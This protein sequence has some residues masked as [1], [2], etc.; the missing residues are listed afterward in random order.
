[1][2]YKKKSKQ[3]LPLLKKSPL[4]IWER[5]TFVPHFFHSTII[6]DIVVSL[7]QTGLVELGPKRNLVLAYCITT[8]YTVVSFVLPVPSKHPYSK[9]MD[10][11]A[12]I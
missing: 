8:Q 5:G 7:S 3:S 4:K 2:Y 9:K 12:E 11:I 6:T 10:A 1:M